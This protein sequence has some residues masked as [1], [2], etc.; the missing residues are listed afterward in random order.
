MRRTTQKRIYQD[1]KREF[2]DKDG[3]Q[4]ENLPKKVI[5]GIESLLKRKNKSEVIIMKTD[6][7]SKFTITNEKEYLKWEINM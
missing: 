6:K 5:K 7:S 2:C 1:Y 4:E 3:N